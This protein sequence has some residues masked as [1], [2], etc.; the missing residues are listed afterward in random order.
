MTTVVISVGSNMNEPQ[1][2]VQSVYDELG[3]SYMNIQMSSLYLT[4]PVGPVTQDPFVNAIV[5]FDTNLAAPEVLQ[6]LL[7]LERKAG[8]NRDRE[9]PRGP[10]TLD[11]DIILFGDEIWSEEALS[12]PHPRFRERRC[13]LEP[14]AEIVADQQDPV[15][16]KNI[17]QLLMECRDDSWITLLEEVAVSL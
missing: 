15:T 4:Q 14:A 5:R 1:S 8:R 11:L 7:N 3:K 12:I 9:I 16:K 17:D 13:V 2:Q 10:R 6:N